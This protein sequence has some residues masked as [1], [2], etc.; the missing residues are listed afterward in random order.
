MQIAILQISDVHINS[1]ADPVL[2]RFTAIA[3]ALHQ[4]APHAS[5][6]IV[7]I[8]GDV[9]YSGQVSQYEAALAFFTN[10][11]TELLKYPGIK[12]VEFIAVP[13]NHDCDFKHESDVREYLLRDIRALYESDVQ[14]GSDR[15]R[16]IL[17]VHNNF[18]AFNAALTGS[19]EL[20][21]EERL[22]FG[23]L[24]VMGNYTIKFQCYNTAWLSRKNEIQGKLFFPLQ[25]LEPI[26]ADANICISI[27]HHPYNWLDANNYRMLKDVVEQTS[28]IVLTGH[29]HQSGVSSIE[30]FSGEHLQY[31]EGAALQGDQGI[32]DSG[33]NILL[34]DINE[35]EE[36]IQT[37]RWNSEQYTAKDTKSW[38][39]LIKNPSRE[40]HLFRVNQL[41]F[42]ELC[43]PGAAFHHKR[44]RQLRLK[45]IF[46]FPDFK[47]LSIA[48][49]VG[50]KKSGVLYSKDALDY[51]RTTPLVVVPGSHDIGKTALLR[52]LYLELSGE[53][54]PI[55]ISGQ[56]LRGK[57][58]DRNVEKVIATAVEEQYDRAAV[59]RFQQLSPSRRLLLLDD[60]ELANQTRA[61]EYKLT[62]LLKNQFGK[63]IITVSDIFR[64]R[65]MTEIAAIE[66]SLRD[67]AMLEIKELGHR[68]RAHLIYK[69]LSLGRDIL[70]DL[71]ALEFEVR[72]TEKI[73]TSLL[74]RNVV[75]CTPFNVLMLLHMMVSAQPQ[76]TLDASYGALYELLIKTSLAVAGPESTK[77]VE[78]TFTYVS[79]VA[80]AM[81]EQDRR[82]FTESDLRRIHSQYVERFQFSSEWRQMLSDLVK[83]NVLYPIEGNYRFRY[84]H[85]Y[86]YC[87]AKYFERTIKRNDLRA[88]ELRDKLRWMSVR[89]HNEEFSNIVLFYV[90][91]TEDW[92]VTSYIVSAA[93]QI[94]AEHE[95]ADLES[96]VKFINSIFK[97][98]RRLVLPDSDVERHQEQYRQQRDEAEQEEDGGFVLAPDA[99]Y[100]KA[101]S[102]LH[103]VAIAFKTLDVLGQI[104]RS[105][106]ATLEG[107]QKIKIVKSC[108]SLGLRT[109]RALLRVAEVN[110]DDLRIYFSAIIKERCALDPEGLTMEEV[111]KRSD[112]AIIWLT[113]RCAYGTIKRISFAVGHHQLADIYDRV[114]SENKSTA[115]GLVD[116]EVKLEHFS[117]LPEFEITRMRDKVVDNI[118]GY[119]VLR[120]M[121]GD[122]L[123][124]YR[125]NIR[126]LQKFGTMFQIE[127]ATNA[128]HLLT[129][130]KKE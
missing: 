114:L 90:H 107:D 78:P 2:S 51:F 84:P 38:K 55:F 95:R 65:E 43:S 118:F 108:Y 40:R 5:A 28:D 56:A 53:T 102:D 10:L 97:E 11:R 72:A 12:T 122:F 125:I 58:S 27:F 25:S 88:S 1:G 79:L 37:F 66:D 54:V 105:L 83:A 81:F 48:S 35:G 14:T 67:F 111:A 32:L 44:V 92:D 104:L 100:D 123:Y 31:V 39:P 86:Y 113:H 91:L 50:Q 120:Q 30:R 16:A 34:L 17:N 18:F 24:V 23:R 9:A 101:L 42:D 116:L 126:A 106:T 21:F 33:F 98:T 47:K 63:I 80:Y 13:G 70:T 36:R 29:E 20:A 82:A 77:D 7:A 45:D 26:P 117:T 52:H 127:G 89:L 8:S 119:S 121:I 57:I 110:I 62:E 130:F 128:E 75:P 94:Y 4:A 22:S 87:V 64:I 124:L 109:L 112:E 71:P 115:M 69:W 85:F 68:L 59:D 61:N 76:S 93:D 46:I 19:K 6:C 74:G 60:L 49:M 15:A 41:Y 129:G 73:I 96:D 103:K 3:A 99:Q